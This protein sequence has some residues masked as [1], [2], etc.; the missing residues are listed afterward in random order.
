MLLELYL[1]VLAQT[2]LFVHHFLFFANLVFHICQ[3]LDH[4]LLLLFDNLEPEL[5]ELPL[6]DSFIFFQLLQLLFG[7]NLL[8]DVLVLVSMPQPA[9][10]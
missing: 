8:E 7:F 3:L 1:S 10:R 2:L 4:V 9:M 6:P 5:F